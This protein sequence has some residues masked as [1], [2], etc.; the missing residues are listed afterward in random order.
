MIKRID[1][2]RGYVM[3]LLTKELMNML[4]Q[5]KPD[6]FMCAETGIN[7]AYYG[8][9]GCNDDCTRSCFGSCGTGCSW[10]CGRGCSGTCEF[11]STHG[12]DKPQR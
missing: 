3:K 12:T 10:D 7:Y 5:F 11:F 1:F 8:C 4:D 2:E 9:Y 6:H